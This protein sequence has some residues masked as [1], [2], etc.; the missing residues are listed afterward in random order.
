MSLRLNDSELI[1]EVI[2]RTP[3]SA[4]RLVLQSLPTKLLYRLMMALSTLFQ[5]SPQWLQFHL[6]WVKTLFV[7]HGKYIKQ[8]R[9]LY[10]TALR[11]LKKNMQE[12]YEDL[13]TITHS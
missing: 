1:D 12:P 10:A 3:H 8:H 6:I 9:H 2:Q 7:V 13:S 11:H 4:L 5:S